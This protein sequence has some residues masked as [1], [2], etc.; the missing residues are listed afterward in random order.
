MAITLHQLRWEAMA[1]EVMHYE[2]SYIDLFNHRPPTPYPVAVGSGPLRI[3]K[4]PN[5]RTTRCAGISLEPSCAIKF[6]SNGSKYSKLIF[7]N[8]VC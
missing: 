7:K 1:E 3:D 6:T 5:R 4:I 2:D 8:A